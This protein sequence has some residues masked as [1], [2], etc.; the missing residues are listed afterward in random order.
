MVDGEPGL[1]KSAVFN[2][3]SVVSLYLGF[4]NAKWAGIVGGAG[5]RI[6]HVCLV[7]LFWAIA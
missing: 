3:R 2:H 5:V 1:G 4:G 6:Y 7:V